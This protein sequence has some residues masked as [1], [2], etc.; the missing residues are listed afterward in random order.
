MHIDVLQEERMARAKHMNCHPVDVP[1]A[2]GLSVRVIN[3]I[4]KK[5]ETKPR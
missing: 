2:D 3:N 4:V 1:G 5:C